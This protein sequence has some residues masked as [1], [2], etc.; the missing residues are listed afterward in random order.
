[1]AVG[2]GTGGAVGGNAGLSHGLHSDSGVEPGRTPV[3]HRGRCGEDP[4]LGEKVVVIGGGNVAMDA[5]R[6]ARRYGSVVTVLYRRREIDMPA[7][8]E[9]IHDA[10]LEGIEFITQ[11]IPIK[12][13]RKDDKLSLIWNK[14]EMV[15]QPDG[16]RPKP[17]AIEG[18]IHDL[19]IDN[20]IT[21]IGQGADYSF[22]GDDIASQIKYKRYKIITNNKK[23]T[24][25]PKVFAGGDI[26]NNT[27]DAISAIADGHTAAKG[28][29]DY[30]SRN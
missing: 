19:R 21:A 11:A 23:Q 26:V 4:G 25:L 13:E 16:G 29:H 10:H 6:T 28:I 22:L 15:E 27:A 8:D 9:E 3:R 5:A 20:L 24:S 1:M 17:V 2:L 14:A 30:L 7:D 18:E 12:L